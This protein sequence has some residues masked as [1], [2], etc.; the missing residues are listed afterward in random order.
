MASYARD[1]ILTGNGREASKIKAILGDKQEIDR[2]E[3]RLQLLKRTPANT[4]S[5]TCPG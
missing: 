5:G 2:A 3:Q 4:L 1:V